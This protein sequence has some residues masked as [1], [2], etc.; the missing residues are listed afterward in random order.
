ML[1]FNSQSAVTGDVKSGASSISRSATSIPNFSTSF[2]SL[3]SSSTATA[4]SS[5]SSAM[6][7]S[8][9]KAFRESKGVLFFTVVVAVVLDA[10]M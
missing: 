2:S 6:A 4:A 10:G 8:V 7:A 1:I 5:S 9:G 3:L